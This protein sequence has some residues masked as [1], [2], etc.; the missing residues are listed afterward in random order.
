MEFKL[1]PFRRMKE[2]RK[3]LNSSMT[4][5]VLVLSAYGAMSWIDP[6]EKDCDDRELFSILFFWPAMKEKIMKEISCRPK[7]QERKMFS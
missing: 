6:H 3:S 5:A 2:E 7:K 4:R 1:A